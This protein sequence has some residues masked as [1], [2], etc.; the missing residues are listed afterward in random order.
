MKYFKL[1]KSMAEFVYKCNRKLKR[2]SNEVKFYRT[3]NI[4]LF[5]R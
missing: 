1:V 4:V 5:T 2:S 3:Y